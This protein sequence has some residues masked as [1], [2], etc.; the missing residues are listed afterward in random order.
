MS[1]AMD[2]VKVVYPDARIKNNSTPMFQVWGTH[3]NAGM[4]PLSQ[5]H[6][7]PDDAWSEAAGSLSQPAQTAAPAQEVGRTC[8]H[9]G[10]PIRE[11]HMGH[12]RNKWEHMDGTSYC[13]RDRY[14]YTSAWPSP[15]PESLLPAVTAQDPEEEVMNMRGYFES[16]I[17]PLPAAVTAQLERS[18]LVEKSPTVFRP[19]RVLP[20]QLGCECEECRTVLCFMCPNRADEY[21]GDVA[22]CP[23]HYSE[24][25]ERS[26]N[27]PAPE[28]GNT[29]IKGLESR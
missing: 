23:D 12:V 10:E 17:N 4:V 11:T 29:A 16:D 5:W 6:L 21:I 20:S 18:G 9:C 22:V 13:K 15:I 3:P 19:Q 14:R 1:K 8:E 2:V 24:A 25:T 7:D 26:N 27:R 28:S